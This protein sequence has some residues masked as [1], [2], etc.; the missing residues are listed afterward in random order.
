M[1]AEQLANFGGLQV[2]KTKDTAVALMK[3]FYGVGPKDFY[4][5]GGSQGGHEAL[6]AAQWYPNDYNG[7]LVQF[8]AYDI[9][10]M[11]MGS[12]IFSKALYADNGYGLGGS[13]I[14]PGQMQLIYNYVLATCANLDGAPAVDFVRNV[15]ACVPLTQNLLNKID[16]PATGGNPL[17]CP[18]GIN[19]AAQGTALG[20]SCL[21]DGQI[22]A[23]GIIAAPWSAPFPLADGKQTYPKWPIIEGGSFGASN[24]LCVAAGGTKCAI[25]GNNLGSTAAYHQ[26]PAPTDAFQ[27]QPSTGTIQGLITENLNLDTILNFNIATQ[28]QYWPRLVQLTSLIDANNPDLTEFMIKGGKV[29][30]AF[31]R[32]DDSI[33]AWNSPDYYNAVVSFFGQATTDSFFK[34]YSIP[35]MGHGS[36]NFVPNWDALGALDSWVNGGAAPTNITPALSP[37]G[38][39]MIGGDR[40]A[41]L[42]VTLG[43]S[44]PVCQWPQYP[45]YTGPASPT[46]AQINNGL[47][48]TCTAKGQ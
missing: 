7:V 21:G 8:P 48:Y 34:Y 19:T 11:H 33:S 12:N 36:G 5:V 27:L 20:D 46:Q 32:A 29:I 3:N 9:T 25:S 28:T 6:V 2:K 45:K 22:T 15:D 43:R 10:L 47:N 1:N 30:M 42:A 24:Q 39:Y 40:N 35:G 16:L 18:G 31:G 41:N 38:A 37:N 4:F 26:P 44:L 23:L 17:R 13:W 14:S